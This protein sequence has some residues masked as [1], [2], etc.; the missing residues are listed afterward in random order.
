MWSLT[1]LDAGSQADGGEP[2]QEWSEQ[3][4][5]PA[6]RAASPLGSCCSLGDHPSL[7][8]EGQQGPSSSQLGWCLCSRP[9]TE[10]H[11]TTWV[12]HF[13]QPWEVQ[14]GC[15]RSQDYYR[16]NGKQYISKHDQSSDLI[17]QFRLF[18]NSSNTKSCIA[19]KMVTFTLME[20]L[21][22]SFFFF[23]IFW[24]KKLFVACHCMCFMTSIPSYN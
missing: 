10:L 14:H 2:Y 16:C 12:Q 18:Y 1:A 6:L 20:A 19:Y 21:K 13:H 11:A 17:C 7:S 22:P 8:R 23:G 5:C 15:H 4:P 24:L 3:R 9:S